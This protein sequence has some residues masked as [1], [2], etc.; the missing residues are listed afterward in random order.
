MDLLGLEQILTLILIIG[1]A[2]APRPDLTL[3]RKSGVEDEIRENAGKVGKQRPRHGS[4]K[5]P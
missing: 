3:R 5:R 4:I 1:S 2:E